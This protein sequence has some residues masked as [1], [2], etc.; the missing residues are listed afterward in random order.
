[1]W[2]HLNETAIAR[3]KGLAVA[4]DSAV[5]DAWARWWLL[6]HQ[7]DVLNAQPSSRSESLRPDFMPQVYLHSR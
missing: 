3:C 4:A 1:M 7:L 2:P 5:A 6:P